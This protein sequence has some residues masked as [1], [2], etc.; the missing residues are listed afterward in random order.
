MRGLKAV[1]A[2]GWLTA[3]YGVFGML[4]VP[5]LMILAAI[6]VV[7]GSFWA[8]TVHPLLAVALVV[9]CGALFVAVVKWE[10][11]RVRRQMPPEDRD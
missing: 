4:M 6:F 11:A 10:S 3:A 8:L 1:K 7:I 9:V 2:F 5:F